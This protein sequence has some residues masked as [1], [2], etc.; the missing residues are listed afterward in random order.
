MCAR[1]IA[2][3]APRL[4]VAL[5]D[6]FHA[7]DGP[8]RIAELDCVTYGPCSADATGSGSPAIMIRSPA[9]ELAEALLRRRRAAIIFRHAPAQSGSDG[10]IA[11]HLHPLARVAQRGRTTSRRCFASAG[12]R[13]VMPAFGAYT[14]GLNMRDRAFAEV[15]ATRSSAHM[16]GRRAVLSDRRPPL[17]ARHTLSASS[18][19]KRAYALLPIGGG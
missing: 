6:S 2:R 15:F 10:E 12:R 17:P 9:P 11:G 8:A 16:L 4:V 7:Q 13:L 18:P 19:R 1:L 5:G 14:G 3:Y